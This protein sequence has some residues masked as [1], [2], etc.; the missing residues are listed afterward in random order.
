MTLPPHVMDALL[1][2]TG[3][4]GALTLVWLARQ[5]RSLLR[6]PRGAAGEAAPDPLEAIARASLAAPP[7]KTTVAPTATPPPPEPAFSPPSP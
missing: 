7:P 4:T 3:F 1:I 5:V 2:A 6:A